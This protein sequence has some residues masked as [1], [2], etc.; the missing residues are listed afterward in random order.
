MK[1]LAL[2]IALAASPGF[3]NFVVG[4]NAELVQQMRA[5]ADGSSNQKSLYVWGEQGSGRTHLLKAAV[6]ACPFP[7]LYLKGGEDLIE[8][9]HARLI[10][11][12]DIETL[13]DAAQI[14]AF[15]L[16][17]R[18]REEGGAFI[19]S[20]NVAPNQ[21][22]LRADLQTRLT[23]GLVYNINRLTDEEKIAALHH[24]AQQRGFELKTEVANYLL[25][26]GNRDMPGLIAI[27][28]ALDRYSLETKR[29]VTLPLLRSVLQEAETVEPN[30]P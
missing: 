23:W 20:G 14:T 29:P 13:D 6:E 25:R 24:H 12:D 8:D 16:F 7:A 5:V 26:H 18:L 17:N 2:D 4:R 3:D 19:A 1:Q 11:I 22:A 9:S 28:D 10:A 15:H 30:R 27:L 21:L